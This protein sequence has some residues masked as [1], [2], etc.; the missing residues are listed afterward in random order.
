MKLLPA[1][2]FLLIFLLFSGMSCEENFPEPTFSFGNESEFRINQRYYSTDGNYTFI[3]HEIGDSRC[4][5]G[6]VCV[7]QGEISVKGEW[8]DNKAKS[9]VELH[10][11]LTDLQKM[12]NGIDIQII[13]TKP[14]PRNGTVI[15]P[16]HKIIT[17][18]IQK[19]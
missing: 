14:Y 19:R 1:I 12:P 4:P 2:K 16:E 10:S 11:V 9:E 6:V 13:D 18:V 8:T 15:K 5:E 17:L 3:I 7:W